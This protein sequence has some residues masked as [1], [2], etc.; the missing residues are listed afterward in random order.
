MMIMGITNT[1]SAA[2]KIGLWGVGGLG[3][4]TEESQKKRA[5]HRWEIRSEVS[6]HLLPHGYVWWVG[7]CMP[8]P[9]LLIVCWGR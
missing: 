7:I 6:N 4:E 3:G 1:N 8:V 5:M 9:L 2:Q